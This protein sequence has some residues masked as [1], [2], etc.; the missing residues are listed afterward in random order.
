V[1]I[2]N[3]VNGELVNLYRVVQHHLEEFIRHFKWAIIS[4]QMFEWL[5][6]ASTDLMTD[7]QRAARFYY[8]QHIAFG[9][10][11]TGQLLELAT[12][13]KLTLASDMKIN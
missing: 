12:T 2:I 1:E 9:A 6:A 5:K 13:G 10:K 11:V 3:D 8:L 4:R 7:I